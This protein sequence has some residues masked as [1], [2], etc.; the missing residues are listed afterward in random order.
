MKTTVT[1]TAKFT[2]AHRLAGKNIPCEALHGHYYELDFT[3]ASKKL[4]GGMVVEFEEAE[5]RVQKWVDENWNHTAILAADDKELG[6]AISKITKQ[7]IF[8]YKGIP[9]SENLAA[10]LLK[11]VAPKLFKGTNAKCVRVDWKEFSRSF[12]SCSV[13]L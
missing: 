6:E 8:Y 9:T 4:N 2:A 7:K 12:Y 13:E 5:R 1:V 10:Y 3:F 11:E